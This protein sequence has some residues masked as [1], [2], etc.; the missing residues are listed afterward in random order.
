MRKLQTFTELLEITDETCGFVKQ[1]TE[2]RFLQEL[3]KLRLLCLYN[4]IYGEYNKEIFSCLLT[5][6]VKFLY[7]VYRYI[8]L[9]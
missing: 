6:N 8:V 3:E 5:R 1:R 7:D 4:E 2:Q 9:F